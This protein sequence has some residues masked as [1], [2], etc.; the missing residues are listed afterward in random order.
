MTTARNRRVRIVRA[1]S[2]RDPAQL[3]A[4]Y[5]TY[6][7]V[8]FDPA[9]SPRDARD[10]DLFGDV[11]HPLGT[12][13]MWANQGVTAQLNFTR[14]RTHPDY[15]ENGHLGTLDITVA[16]NVK[17]CDNL[18]LQIECSGFNGH[19]DLNQIA[20]VTPEQLVAL[21]MLLPR[22]IEMARRAGYLGG[23]ADA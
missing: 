14:H 8:V 15:V 21:G 12:A 3:A 22:V 13:D 1:P 7:G 19:E 17:G 20:A 6:P 2:P 10:A 11:G 9:T 4:E 5:S 16:R 18:T 23:N